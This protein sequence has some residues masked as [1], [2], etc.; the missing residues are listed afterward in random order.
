MRAGQAGAG[1][2][3]RIAALMTLQAGSL[4]AASALHLS[5]LVQR[6]ETGAGIAEAVIGLALATGAVAVVRRGSRGRATAL[7][8]TVFAIAGFIYGLSLT[9]R[10][11]DLAD[12][13]YHATVLPLLIL[14][15]GLIV[16]TKHADRAADGRRQRAR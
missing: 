4:A 6:R 3:G 11:G 9:V 1:R 13:T 15:L 8:A 16:G 14:T 2:H 5:G 12:I 10:A 7:A